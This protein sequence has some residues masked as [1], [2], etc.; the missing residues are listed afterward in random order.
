[1]APT[2]ATATLLKDLTSRELEVLSWMAKGYRNPTIAELLFLQ[3]KTVERHV[4]GIYGKLG[5]A[6]D[7]KHPRVHAITL[8]L[9]AMGILPAEDFAQ[10]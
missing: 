1:M 10:G 5:A 2:D 9:R 4:N 3:P 8:Y 7:S 6:L